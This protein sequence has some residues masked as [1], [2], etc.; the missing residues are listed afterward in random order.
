VTPGEKVTAAPDLDIGQPQSLDTALAFLEG[1]GEI[2][3][4]IRQ[5]DWTQSSLGSAEGWPQCLRSAVSICLGSGFPIAIYWGPELTLLYNDAWSLMIGTKHPWA[6]GQPAREVWPE[7]WDTIGPLF[8]HVLSTGEATRSK[9]QLLALRRR[10]YTEECYFDYTFT[11]VRS[12]SGQV[13]GIFNAVLETT[14]RVIGERRS[15][16][17]R[18]LAE[19]ATE[20]RTAQIA[21]QFIA[22][23]LGRASADIPF[24][25]LYLLS[26]EGTEARLGGTAGLDAGT[27]ASP[28]L[29][30]L[31]GPAGAAWA[32][33]VEQ[34][35]RTGVAQL[36]GNLAALFA[37]LPGGPWP[38]SPGSALVL[39]VSRVRSERPYAVLIAGVSPRSALDTDYRAFF[40]I[41]TSHIAQA[42]ANAEAHEKE[43]NRAEALAEIDR[44]QTTFFSNVSH[45]FRTPLTLMLGPL[46]EILATSATLPPVVAELLS[47][48]YRNG[49]RLQKLVN[50]LLDFS[51]IEAGRE[52]ASYEPTDL[53]TLTGQLASTFSSAMD[54]A[55]LQF[56]V[57]CQPLRDPVY[58]DREMWEK[59]VLNLLSNAFKYTFE[60][61]ITVRLCVQEERAELS[62]EDTGIGIPE[63]ELSHLFERFH[64]VEGAR[65]RTQEGTG[66][67]LAL[68]AELIKLHGG[69]VGVRSTVGKGS[70]FTVSLPFGAAHLPRERIGAA[71]DLSSNALD[72]GPYVEQAAC[73]LPKARIVELAPTEQG[74]PDGNFS[75]LQKIPPPAAS[76]V[77]SDRVLV[78]DDNAD[79]REYVAS[80]LAGRYEVETVANGEEALASI[81]LNPPDL[82]LSDVRMP[83]L[84][85]FG[86]LKAIRTNP[87]IRALPVILLSARASGE[88]RVDGLD[89]GASDYLVKPFSAREL[90]ARVGAHL[91]MTRVRKQA[92]ARESDLL[93]KAEAAR[94]A[95]AGMLESITDAFATFDREWR[96]IYVNPK[97]E[98]LMG[99]R[100]DQLLGKNY[101]KI[102]PATLGT[103]VEQ[104]YRRATSDQV[105]VEFEYFHES[106]DRW[107]TVK[108][109]PTQEGG[110]SIYF[111]DITVQKQ[112]EARL[113]ESQERLRAIYDGTYEYI[114]LL[115]PD[116]TL[117]EANRASLEFA[118]NTR[119]DVVGKPFWDTPWFTATPGAPEA[120][121]QSVTRAAAGEFVRYEATVN[122]PT[123]ELATFDISFH[124]VRNEHG[125]VILIVPEGR[126]ITERK[127]VE[128]ALREQDALREADRRKWREL[129]FQVPAAVATLRGPDHIF[130][131]FNDEYLRVVG[132]SAEQLSGKPV[133]DALPEVVQQGYTQLLD[134]V[135]Q[136]GIPHVAKETLLRLDVHGDGVLHDA[137]LSF[138][139]HATRDDA[140][141]IDGVF[142]HAVD[143]TDLVEA[144]KRIE[145]SNERF[146]LALTATRGLVYDWEPKSGRVMRER[147]LEEL[148]GWKEHEV[149]DTSEWWYQQIHPDDLNGL[150]GATEGIPAGQT[151]RVFAYRIR[152]RSGDWRWVEDHAVIH[153]N[154]SGEI[155]RVIGITLDIDARKQAEEEL[156][157]SRERF[158]VAVRAV[159]DLIWT[160]NAKGGMEGE[161]PGWSAFTGQ[162]Y[163]E[164]Q[165]YGWSKAIHPDDAQPTIDAWNQAVAARKMFI[166]EHRLRRHDGVWRLFSIRALPM[167]D[168]RGTVREWVGVHTD[169]TDRRQAEEALRQSEERF[170]QVAESMP[171]VVWSATAEGVCDY[172][173]SRWTELTGCD[174]AATRAGA[175]RANMLPEDLDTLDRAV[176]EGLRAGEPY[177]FECRFSSISD[178]TLRWYLLRA[179][180]VR[181]A[182]GEIAKWLGTST[183]I[184]AQKRSAEALRL[185]EWRLRF[186]LEAAN[187]GSWELDL[188]TQYTHRS[189]RHD[190]IFGYEHPVS[191]W[192][193]AQFLGHVIAE[194]QDYV[195]RSFQ[196]SLNEGDEW[197]FECR[198]RRASDGAI[199]WIWGY[200]KTIADA[201]GTPNMM[202]GLVGDI[203]ERKEAEAA[204]AQANE[205]LLRA[206]ADLEQFGYSASHDLQEPLRSVIIYSELLAKRY[207]AKLDGQA[208]E[209]LHY[210]NGGASRME[211]LIRDL[212]AYTQVKKLEEPGE[213]DAMQ[214]MSDT[215]ANLANAIME[216]GAQITCENLPAVK[217]HK[218]HLQQLFQNLIGNALKYR[219]ENQPLVHV[220]AEKRDRQWL[221]SVSDNG[222]GIEAEY[223]ERIFGLFKRLHTSD[224]YS[225]TGIGLAICQ[226]IV[227]RYSG[228]IW[229]ESELGKGSTFY[230]TLPI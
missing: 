218:V 156:R 160:N 136:T 47:V 86:L 17:V 79:T 44:A 55:G 29:I 6:L 103:I 82:V 135:Y 100:R 101:W 60:G 213:S 205:D 157:M 34:V 26:D 149:P 197:N 91:E 199:R 77:F 9:D 87:E 178:K 117:L 125:E 51:R 128:S 131:Q 214:I 36:V 204:L 165:G 126:N 50:S 2:G 93:A 22:L 96:F 37:P 176:S 40:E 169:I 180:P 41:V 62:V 83:G 151:M 191:D 45:E 183:D 154:E 69:T 211:L 158:R 223:K 53:A 184:D 38:E 226:R 179:I 31:P 106:L 153:R 75:N 228:R 28:V 195:D 224:E 3:A 42:L 70:T 161:Q 15:R 95:A 111:S 121:R 146:T 159:S 145:E 90:L 65:G 61:K 116:G 130:E 219:S 129:F 84:D 193:Y 27:P 123:G 172:V 113:R 1:G 23:T 216:S 76:R 97:T 88:D 175:F 56:T 112:A 39:P 177:G 201:Y 124:P 186:T 16:I 11:P 173:N 89:A 229:V 43:R 148:T 18:E 78:A 10:G 12:E 85:G 74:H 54:T 167:L 57:D 81:L 73:W 19:C 138:V 49:L 139:Y 110:L 35:V 119:E 202:L 137:Y 98:Q 164:Y 144:R 8:Q 206:N 194:D 58:V 166:F 107:F 48:T 182:N 20:S 33:P 94:D 25:L 192:T 208:L 13:E 102:F 212:L 59:I 227:G 109:Y 230:F 188:R 105:P 222:I 66:I 4:R 141:Q 170:R 150:R 140:G 187:F 127:L 220:R 168:E 203:T 72:A 132:R 67:G 162:S 99:M 189:P 52:Q 63:H 122:H 21:C 147:G 215:L 71:R 30:P 221:F 7:I 209:M 217:V 155:L 225:G 92:A 108:G 134:G 118:G 115:A 32:W 143:V 104:Q 133:R 185:S 181:N 210:L 14:E 196:Q 5:K 163:D 120:V 46:E 207:G 200:G 24:A 142:V 68:V 80:L 64:R 114:G 171:Q 190:A 152:H 174:L 198:I